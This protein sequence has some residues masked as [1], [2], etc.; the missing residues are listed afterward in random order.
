MREIQAAKQQPQDIACRTYAI[1]R[2]A[3]AGYAVNSLVAIGQE[4]IMVDL[5]PYAA[6]ALL[7]LIWLRVELI[8]KQTSSVQEEIAN[9]RR[10]LGLSAQLS[11]EPSEKVRELAKDPR[12]KVEAIK[13]YRM[14]SG[15][16]LRQA[17]AVIQRLQGSAG[18]A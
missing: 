5:L 3:V 2:G 9:L 10:D 16:D 11:V 18:D 1:A 15:A 14:E 13:T 12:A 7:L 8:A 17:Q 6:G 4:G